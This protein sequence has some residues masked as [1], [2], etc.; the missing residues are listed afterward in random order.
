MRKWIVAPSRKKDPAMPNLVE[1]QAV[2]PVNMRQSQGYKAYT[3]FCRQFFEA[4]F[5]FELGLSI[6]GHRRRFRILIERF[7]GIPVDQ[8][9]AAKYKIFDPRFDRGLDEV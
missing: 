6:T 9:T 4:S 7:G 3:C 5:G 1:K 2:G 8:Q